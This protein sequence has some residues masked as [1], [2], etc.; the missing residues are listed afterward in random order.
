MFALIV[1]GNAKLILP[2]PS[3]VVEVPALVALASLIVMLC[4]VP[5]L[6]VT[7]SAPPS[8]GVPLMLLVVASLVASSKAAE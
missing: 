3:T 1:A 5:H 4:A 6:A 8:N 2:E 7:M